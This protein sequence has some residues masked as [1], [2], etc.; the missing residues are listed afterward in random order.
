[1]RDERKTLLLAED[2]EDL[3]EVVRITLEQPRFHILEA[4]DGPTALRLARENL[5]DVIV[6]DW[7]LPGIDGLEILQALRSDPETARICILMLTARDTEED[8]MNGLQAG[9]DA[10]LVKPFSPIEL[11]KAVEGALEGRPR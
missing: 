10:Y 2:N 8:V 5:P 11:V 1:M 3:R 7:M 4:R 9:A 6:L